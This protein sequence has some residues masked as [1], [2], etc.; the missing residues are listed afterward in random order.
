MYIYTYYIYVCMYVH[1]YVYR[2]IPLI[3]IQIGPMRELRHWP[4]I[5]GLSPQTHCGESNVTSNTISINPIM[6]LNVPSFEREMTAKDLLN[7]I[8]SLAQ[9][10]RLECFQFSNPKVSLFFRSICNC[11][12]FVTVFVIY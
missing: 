4:S 7:S 5:A 8:T 9:S 6:K 11:L 10:I 12:V 1:T 2:Y 3:Q